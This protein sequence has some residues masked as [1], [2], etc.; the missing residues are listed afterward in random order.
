MYKGKITCIGCGKTGEEAPRKSKDCLCDDCENSLKI[1]RAIV[2]ERNLESKSYCLDE[3]KIGSFKWNTYTDD[4]ENALINLLNS[5]SQFKET[6]KIWGFRESLYYNKLLSSYGAS[7]EVILPVETFE[8]AKRL[9]ETLKKANDELKEKRQTYKEEVFKELIA[10]KHKLY[11]EIADEKNKIYN[12]GV[13]Y[14]R[15][16]LVQLNNG[17]IAPNEI[18]K[19]VKPF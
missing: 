19:D 9:C 2:K 15:N 8:A 16:L 11:K 7:H 14:G 12:D 18:L 17:E 5:F 13:H 1:G 6:N 10:E 3:F 4:I